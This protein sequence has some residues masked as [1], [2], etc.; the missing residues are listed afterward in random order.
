MAAL[1]IDSGALLAMIDRHDAHH[2]A[3]ATFIR[4]YPVAS[5]LVPDPI[6]AETMTLVKAR[7]GSQPAIAL[8]MGLMQSNRFTLLPCTDMDRQETWAI[9][10]RYSDKDWSYADCSVLAT[11]RRL[12][13]TE[14]FAFDHHFDQMAELRRVP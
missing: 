1:I 13:V 5:F 14:V 4:E 3:A 7:L 2:V 9:F 10:S 8:G 12:E 11:A 6:F